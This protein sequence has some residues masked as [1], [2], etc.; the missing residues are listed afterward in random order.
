MGA[1]SGCCKE[2]KS[3]SESFTPSSLPF[4]AHK[5]VGRTMAGPREAERRLQKAKAVAPFLAHI[6]TLNERGS[7]SLW[8]DWLNHVLYTL[9]DSLRNV[10]CFGASTCRTTA[11]IHYLPLSETL[12]GLRMMIWCGLNFGVNKTHPPCLNEIS[13]CFTR[14]IA[15]GKERWQRR[16]S[17]KVSPRFFVLI[18]FSLIISTSSSVSS[19]HGTNIWVGLKLHQ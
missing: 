11:C 2:I 17:S 15:S 1:E 6:N 12:K 16:S 7:H 19:S 5:S 3:C 18:A 4:T 8:V 10:P 13:F 14:K 9:F